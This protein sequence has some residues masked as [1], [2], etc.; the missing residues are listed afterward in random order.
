MTRE[1]ELRE[2]IPVP[3]DNFLNLFKVRARAAEVIFFCCLPDPRAVYFHVNVTCFA[4]NYLKS[5]SHFSN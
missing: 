1:N 2:R 5:D 3:H 4:A